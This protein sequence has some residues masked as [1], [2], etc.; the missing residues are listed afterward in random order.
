MNTITRDEAKLMTPGELRD[1]TNALAN[2]LLEGGDVD[3]HVMSRVK[4]VY[5]NT[6]KISATPSDDFAWVA[7]A[8]G[9]TDIREGLRFVYA[10]GAKIMASDGYRIHSAQSGMQPGYYCPVTRYRLSDPEDLNYQ[11]PA[12][13]FER[14]LVAKSEP[15]KPTGAPRTGQGKTALIE[16]MADNGR[17]MCIQMS[18]AKDAGYGKDTRISM[19]P[20]QGSICLQIPRGVAILMEYKSC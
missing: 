12:E 1:S 17:R 13:A 10:T 9:P 2:L 6:L 5:R 4:A 16:F 8:V 15:A 11:F 19:N 7:K 14:M 3:A 20:T 18:Y